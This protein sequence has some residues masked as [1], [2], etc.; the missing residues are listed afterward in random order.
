VKKLVSARSM[1]RKGVSEGRR[2]EFEKGGGDTLSRYCKRSATASRSLSNRRGS[3]RYFEFPPGKL[4]NDGTTARRV[5][6]RGV[7][8]VEG[9]MR[10]DAAVL[11]SVVGGG[12]VGDGR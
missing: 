10:E 5:R 4:K 11:E 2:K 12:R 6:E 8:K 3:S 1:G 7:S 9:K